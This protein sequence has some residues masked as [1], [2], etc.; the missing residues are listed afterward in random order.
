MKF[1]NIKPILFILVLFLIP[2]ILI[3]FVKRINTPDDK[4]ITITQKTEYQ[5]TTEKTLTTYGLV[6]HGGAGDYTKIDFN[7]EL[8]AEYESKL[9]EALK[10]GMANIEK[11]DS[12]LQIVSAVIE[13]LEDSP[14]FNAGKGAV[15]T[16][17]GTNELDA[18]IMDGKTKMTGAVAGVSHI[19]NPIKAALCV[20]EHSKHVLL[21][22]EG[23]EE[24][25]QNNKLEMVSTDYFYTEK[26]WQKLQK[27]MADEKM[28][29]VGCV[30]LDK[31]G[32]LAAG[33]STGGMTNK[34]YGRVGDS[35]IVGAGTYADNQTC[36]ISATGHGEYF[37]RYTV[38]YDIAARIKYKKQNL[39][40]AANDAI[41]D[42]EKVGG[43]GGV[44]GIDKKGTVSMSFNTLSM[45]RGSYLKNGEPN[46][47]LFQN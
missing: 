35:P 43:K 45:M 42:L 27:S 15:F 34:M 7:A 12:A 33:T 11:G 28:G 19:K 41:N 44:I 14:L 3:Q 24:F 21:I 18:C 38:A 22:G 8:V 46:V 13:L 26:Q 30:V 39:T 5:D 29:T 16:H 6:I 36:A 1:N 25:A 47:W 23:A 32:N 9:Y 40:D 37:I 17:K 10:I 31:Y 2:Y 20:L 4:E